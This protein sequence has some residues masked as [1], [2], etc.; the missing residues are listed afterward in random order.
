ML[1]ILSLAA[2]FFTF[3]SIGDA[4]WS[5]GKKDEVLDEDPHNIIF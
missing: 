5:T 1:V 2:A 3:V 4:L